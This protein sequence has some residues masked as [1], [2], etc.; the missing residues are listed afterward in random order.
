MVNIYGI[1]IIIKIKKRI[2]IFTIV[3]FYQVFN[4]KYSQ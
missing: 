2:Y 1:I 3:L 4:D